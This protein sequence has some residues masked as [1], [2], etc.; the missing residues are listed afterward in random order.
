MDNS[1]TST[2]NDLSRKADS[3]TS[4][5]DNFATKAK[6]AG[7]QILDS[8]FGGQLTEKWGQIRDRSE[9]V[10]NSS[11]EVVRRH[12]LAT[13]STAL[14]VGILTGMILKRRH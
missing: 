11:V 12:P 3:I 4:K 1:M 5:A 7:E 14:A 10:Y 8:D 13:V 2:K 9:D 6:N